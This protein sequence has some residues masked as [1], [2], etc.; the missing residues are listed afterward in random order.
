[1]LIKD[2]FEPLQSKQNTT[3]SDHIHSSFLVVGHGFDNL[4]S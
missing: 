3:E 4:T 2:T 1:M